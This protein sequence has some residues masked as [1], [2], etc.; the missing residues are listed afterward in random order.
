MKFNRHN[1]SGAKWLQPLHIAIV[2]W[3]RVR[4][5]GNTKPCF[6][7]QRIEI[8]PNSD[9][10]QDFPYVPVRQSNSTSFCLWHSQLMMRRE[11]RY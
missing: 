8:Q 1:H 11:V 7:L 3:L 5:A 10:R 2:A 6:T 4:H 9:S